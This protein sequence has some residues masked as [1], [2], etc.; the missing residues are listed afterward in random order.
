MAESAASRFLGN[1]VLLHTIFTFV[2]I[3]EFLYVGGVCRRWRR[4]YISV[5]C[6]SGL[7][8]STKTLRTKAFG[9]AARFAVALDCGLR[10]RSEAAEHKDEDQDLIYDDLK[11][12]TDPIGILTL[13]MDVVGGT[14][15]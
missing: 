13:A 6:T 15:L 7:V 5:C 1:D 12:S 10:F 14:G 8:P 9:T 3:N 11:L 4:R 2:G